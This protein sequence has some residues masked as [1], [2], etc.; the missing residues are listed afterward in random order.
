MIT[1]IDAHYYLAKDLARAVAF[2]RDA[3]LLTVATDFGSS[4]E[5]VLPD[6]S[7]FGIA[8]MPNGEWHESGGVMFAVPDPKQAGERVSAAGGGVY[9]DV[10]E[11]PACSIVWCGDTEGNSFALH[12]R[13]S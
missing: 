11:S 3:L 2:Y 9:T 7:A 10:N 13:K 1:G 12:R 4:V 5:F 8:T 6:G